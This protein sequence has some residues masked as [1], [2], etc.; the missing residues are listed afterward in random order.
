MTG[1]YVTCASEGCDNRMWKEV[2]RLRDSRTGKFACC[3]E[4]WALVHK[5]M[6]KQRRAKAVTTKVEW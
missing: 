6:W 1:R 5:Q 2:S 4:H 3:R